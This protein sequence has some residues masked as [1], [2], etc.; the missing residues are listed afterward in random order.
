MPAPDV[1]PWPYDRDEARR[2]LAELGFGPGEDGVLERD[3]QRLSFTLTTNTGNRVRED[4]LVKVQAQLKEIGVE[5]D[6][7]L[8]HPPLRVCA[9]QGAPGDRGVQPE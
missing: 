4:V 2:R 6:L 9:V 5:V 8:G 1:E 3:G 7:L